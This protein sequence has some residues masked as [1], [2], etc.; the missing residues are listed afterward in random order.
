MAKYLVEV[1]RYLTSDCIIEAPAKDYVEAFVETER[2]GFFRN[3][4]E[5]LTD[6]Y[7]VHVS[8]LDGDEQADIALNVD[9]EVE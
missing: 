9:G 1:T 7:D 2:A 5:G 4:F 6:D 8:E 3:L